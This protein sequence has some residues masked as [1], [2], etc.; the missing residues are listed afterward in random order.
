MDEASLSLYF[1]LSVFLFRSFLDRSVSPGFRSWIGVGVGAG[2]ESEKHAQFKISDWSWSEKLATSLNSIGRMHKVSAANS[3]NACRSQ[4]S[5][6][7]NSY[8]LIIARSAGPN[9]LCGFLS[10]GSPLHF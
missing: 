9:E 4:K 8:K 5:K 3:L 6:G 2:L 7:A 1:T 10:Q